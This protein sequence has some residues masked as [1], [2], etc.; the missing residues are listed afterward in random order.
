M[1]KRNDLEKL[2]EVSD[3]AKLFVDNEKCELTE[4]FNMGETNEPDFSF[5]PNGKC[6]CIELHDDYLFGIRCDHLMWAEGLC[7]GMESCFRDVDYSNGEVDENGFAVMSETYSKTTG[8]TI[9]LYGNH[10]GSF[11]MKLL[12][13]KF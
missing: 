5:H 9:L 11:Y 1:V 2:A 7:E 8:N 6:G 12:H 13:Y 3:M 4:I 10:K